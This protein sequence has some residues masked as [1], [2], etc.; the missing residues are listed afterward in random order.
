MSFPIDRVCQ[1]SLPADYE[2][3][4]VLCD[5]DR[6]Y[7]ATRFSS[8]S[9]LLRTLLE[10]AVDKRSIP[11]MRAVLRELR[12]G[13]GQLSRQTPLFF[14]SA[15]PAQM[16]PILE[17]KMLIDGVDYDGTTFKDWV[18][19]ALSL[20]FARLRE[21]LG[22]KLT[23]LLTA[24]RSLP[25]GAYEL[26]VG[27]DLETDPLAYC[28]YADILAGRL[29]EER[30][31]PVLISLG[32]APCDAE[33][34]AHLRRQLPILPG[35]VRR[36]YIRRERYPTAEAFLDHWP[37]LIAC[38]GAL[39][40]ALALVR[41]EALDVPNVLRVARELAT[42]RWSAEQLRGELNDAARR[43]LLPMGDVR[44]AL[45]DGLAEQGWDLAGLK[46]AEATEE[47]WLAKERDANRPWTPAGLLRG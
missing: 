31:V 39:E 15:S 8:T 23:A 41:D 22:F 36:I 20:R 32:V 18:G 44:A 1:R 7:L 26:M 28:L 35:G 13:P 24:R 19:V 4:A 33:E 25:P 45:L 10:F 21:Q 38:R 3:P 6:T 5:V 37:H 29:P 47:Q 12:R 17:R 30:F 42:Q 34:I 14:L 46:L 11:G 27:D 16:R 9:K 2:G 40:I 43:G